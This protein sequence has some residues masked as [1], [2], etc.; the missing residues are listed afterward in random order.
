MKTLD[1][2]QVVGW[3]VFT[4]ATMVAI[5]AAFGRTPLG[6]PLSTGLVVV[7]P[8][9]GANVVI[10]AHGLDRALPWRL[11]ATT[12]A[13][14]IALAAV[15]LAVGQATLGW[16]GGWTQTAAFAGPCAVLYPLVA[17]RLLPR[18]ARLSALG[19]SPNAGA[20]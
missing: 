2:L 9:I 13:A 6:S 12:V 4:V 14:L 15:V 20:R 11:L 8:M 5:A 18:R 7:P 1:W 3:Y 17:S 19:S 16:Q 10:R